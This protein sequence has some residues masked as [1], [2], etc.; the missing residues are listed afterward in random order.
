MKQW[1][2]AR[3][4]ESIE[5]GQ[6]DIGPEDAA[7]GWQF[8]RRTTHLFYRAIVAGY[9][10]TPDRLYGPNLWLSRSEIYLVTLLREIVEMAGNT[11]AAIEQ[12]EPP[13]D[14]MKLWQADLNFYSR[15]FQSK[16]YVL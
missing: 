2:C 14:F 4:R 9:D 3:M 16:E 15:N 12:R 1:A 8:I 13:G 10:V 5:K 7:H 6:A 11:F